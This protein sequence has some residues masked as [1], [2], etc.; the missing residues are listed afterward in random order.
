MK[1]TLLIP[2]V[3]FAMMFATSCK[4]C[5]TCTAV[6]DKGTQVFNETECGGKLSKASNKNNCNSVAFYNDGTCTCKDGK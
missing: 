1:K 2:V 4:K 3:L 6:N 5:E